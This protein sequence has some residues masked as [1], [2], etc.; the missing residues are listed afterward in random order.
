MM[1]KDTAW[2]I[3][4]QQLTIKEVQEALSSPLPGVTAQSKMAPERPSSQADRWDTPADCRE[5]GVLLLL[6]TPPLTAELH[7]VLTRRPEYPGTHGGQISFPGG[8]REEDETLRETAL[9]ETMEEIGVGPDEVIGKLSPLYIPPSNFCTYP[10]VA[11]SSAR[12]D[13]QPDDKEVAEI[14]ETPLCLLLDATI[15]KEEIWYFQKYGERRVPFFDVFG[16]HVWGATAMILSEFL[17]LLDEIIAT[18]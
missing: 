15:Q 14:I 7:I 8:Q 11:Y 17:T 13:F 18:K 5:A 12:P 16:H 6:Y 3:K 1:T 4:E 9:R 2:T 10:F